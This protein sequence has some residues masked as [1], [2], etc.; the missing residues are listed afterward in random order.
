MIH[1]TDAHA[2]WASLA[3]L[4]V[5]VGSP[6]L[7]A[8]ANTAAA[9]ALRLPLTTAADAPLQ[10]LEL[11]ARAPIALQSPGYADVRVVNSSGQAVPMALSPV[12]R[13]EA[14]RQQTVLQAYPLMGTAAASSTLDSLALR[15]EER[16]S[17]G[18]SER[19]V[20]INPSG[21]AAFATP[22]ESRG[23]PA[24][25]R[26]ISRCAGHSAPRCGPSARR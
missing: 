8:D 18:V 15:I 5:L 16:R 9:Y 24:N 25:I 3:A 6:A 21:G 7:A 14:G 2:V 1:R 17:N 13:A 26:R 22:P 19:V 12:P 23:R 11:P 10:R 4:Y 20:V